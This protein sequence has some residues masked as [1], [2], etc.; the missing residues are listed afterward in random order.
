[1]PA[2]AIRPY[3]ILVRDEA[4][5]Q[6]RYIGRGGCLVAR[7]INAKP[8][9]PEQAERLALALSESCDGRWSVVAKPI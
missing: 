7:R 1:M 9:A 5:R 8:F 3:L 2:L 4:T 6:V